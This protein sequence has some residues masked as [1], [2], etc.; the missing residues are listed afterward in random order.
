MT[1]L[2][3]ALACV[4]AAPS[5]A[6]QISPER[7]SQIESRMSRWQDVKS[8]SRRMLDTYKENMARDTRFNGVAYG[9]KIEKAWPTILKAEDSERGRFLKLRGVLD[10][11]Y[12]AAK[13]AAEDWNL[14]TSA[15]NKLENLRMLYLYG[16][17]LP[18]IID[19]TTEDAGFKGR[20]L[21]GPDW[22]LVLTEDEYKA[23]EDGYKKDSGFS[24]E[25]EGKGA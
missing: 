17:M 13:L 14:R 5:Q 4:F 6:Q 23:V 15:V 24:K 16:N 25:L 10:R 8:Q 11:D 19:Q 7:R 9:P 18:R 3:L 1:R 2:L 21:A 12:R 22:E 20:E